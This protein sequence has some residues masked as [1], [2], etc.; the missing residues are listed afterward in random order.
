MATHNTEDISGEAKAKCYKKLKDVDLDCGPYQLPSDTWNNDPMKWPDLEFPD[1]YVYL[2]KTP[3]AFTKE[4]MKNR[5]SLEAYN[6]FIS[7][8]V[9]TV[10]HYQKLGSNFITLKAE[11]MISLRLNEKPHFPWV[12]INLRGTS[13]ETA[14]RPCIASLGESCS[15]I[16]ALLF[17]LEATV[18]TGFTKKACTD[19]AC[20]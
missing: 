1:I 17:K 8:W 4:S 14:H 12:A 5:K 18:R 13:V 15:H 6:Q 9:R 3:G 11:V 7:S 10:Y 16:G 19:V 2:I 20:A